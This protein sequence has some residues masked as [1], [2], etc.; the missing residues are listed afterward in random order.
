M[1]IETATIPEQAPLIDPRHTYATVTDRI[2][3]IPL[4]RGFHP[5]WLA[6]LGAAMSVAMLF[7]I[8]VLYL[9]ARGIGVWGVNIPVAWGFAIVNFV[10]WIGIGHA[11]TL[12]SAILFLMRQ[13]WRNSI[14]RFAEAMTVFAVAIAGMFPLLHLG[15]IWKFYYLVPYPNTM[16]T[17]PQWRSPLVWDVFA[18]GTYFTVSLLFWYLGLLP[19]LASLRD[20]A[21][22]RWARVA[23]GILSLGWRGSVRHWHRYQTAYLLFAGLSTPLVVS[24]HSIVSMDFATAV[25]P[26]WHTTIFPPFFVAGAIYSG[27]AMVLTLAIPLRAAFRLHDVI[28]L[29]H[30]N[31]MSKVMLTTGLIVAYGYL[32]EMF[33]AFYS[34][35]LPHARSATYR[36]AGDAAPF[37]WALVFCN[38][39]VGQALWFRRVRT[40]PILLLIVSIFI[41]IGMW[42]E[43]FDIVV[44]G[45][46]RDY[47]PSAFGHYVPTIWDIALLV[48]S[49][50]IFGTLMFLFIRLVP[51]ISIFELRELLHAPAQHAHHPPHPGR[52][53]AAETAGPERT[54][55]E[56][57]FLPP[58]RVPPPT[59]L[60]LAPRFAEQQAPAALHGVMAEFEAPDDLIAAAAAVRQ[61][62]Y[63]QV[64]AYS[65]MPVEGLSEVLGLKQTRIPLL[66]LFG[67]LVGGTT[68]YLTQY[69]SAVIDYPWN[70]GGRPLH[71]WPSFIPLTFELSVLGGTLM[72]LVGLLAASGLPRLYHPVFNIPGFERASRDRFFL[73]IQADDPKFDP[74]A[75]RSDLANLN[76]LSVTDVPEEPA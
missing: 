52:D 22:R 40:G 72:G 8:G 44:S 6:L 24:V 48:G 20:R 9:I 71:S 51:M 18:V 34:G 3:D 4:A 68:I 32:M 55:A 63:T 65:P 35:E 66:V 7:F 26:A 75:A 61:Q 1:A 29:R 21:Q 58:L 70:I 13:P 60:P 41:N 46:E 15:R 16:G 2:V 5:A 59:G 10:W 54:I 23:A 25:V 38:V 76:P 47:L 11:G 33:T 30:L 56:A 12:I 43:R 36:L 67:A 31:S 53:E 49:L 14:S 28:T 45:L 69:Y 57:P 39:V 50:G 27:M 19:D 74:A 73:C 17:W 64:E 62:G 37:Y 42:L